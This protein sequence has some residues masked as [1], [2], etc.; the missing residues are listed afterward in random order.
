MKSMQRSQSSSSHAFRSNCDHSP[1]MKIISSQLTVRVPL[2]KR[3]F[4]RI[5]LKVDMVVCALLQSEQTGT[6]E[7]ASLR[8]LSELIFLCWL[9][10]RYEEWNK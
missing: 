7:Y 10:A 9:T 2:W 5:P 4:V 1:N 8:V 6:P 3:P